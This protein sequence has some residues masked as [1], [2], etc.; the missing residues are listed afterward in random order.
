MS[1]RTPL[2]RRFIAALLLVLLTACQTWQST[3]YRAETLIPVEQPSSVRVTWANGEVVTL[4]YPWIRNDSILGTVDQ[5]TVGAPSRDV[6]LLEV[7]GD[8][9]RWIVAI[10]VG[11]AV[12][13]GVFVMAG[14]LVNDFYG[15]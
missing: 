8:N 4:Q 7:R 6:A 13:I 1:T 9:N 11:G 10:I 15:N 3:P 12:L 2:A 5:S 14:A